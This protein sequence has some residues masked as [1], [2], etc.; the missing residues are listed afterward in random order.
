MHDVLRASHW[1]VLAVA[2]LGLLLGILT[3]TSRQTVF[4]WLRGR[5]EW[6]RSGWA[7]IVIGLGLALTQLPWLAGDTTSAI[8]A[9]AIAGAAL[10]VG[11]SLLQFRA[12][13]QP[14]RRP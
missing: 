13:Q 9:L 11:G 1:F 4:P 12:Q 6:K 8:F 7:Q 5:V 14:E 10:I 2:G 3:L